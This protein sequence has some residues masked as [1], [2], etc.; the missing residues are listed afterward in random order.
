MRNA[1]ND[2]PKRTLMG[3]QMNAA[4]RSLATGL[5]ELAQKLLHGLCNGERIFFGD[6]FPG[7]LAE[8]LERG[9]N[10]VLSQHVDFG[11]GVLGVRVSLH[12]DIMDQL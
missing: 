1:T 5:S 8:L 12:P 11:G 3:I 4:E 2:W 10:L 9:V 7:P 6:E